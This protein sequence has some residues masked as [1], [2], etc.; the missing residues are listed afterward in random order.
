VNITLG[1]LEE[2]IIL[3]GL[4][5]A[6]CHF[7]TTP[8]KFLNGKLELYIP[9]FFLHYSTHL[10]NVCSAA[11]A[12]IDETKLNYKDVCYLHE[13]HASYILYITFKIFNSFKVVLGYGKQ[14]KNGPLPTLLF[15]SRQNNNN[16]IVDILRVS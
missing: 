2:R 12:Y 1:P 6:V 8:K 4:H 15:L 13:A 14:I 9:F 3:C 16:A 7:V 5:T 11:T 10:R